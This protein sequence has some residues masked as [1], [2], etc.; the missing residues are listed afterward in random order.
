M[1]HVS[2]PPTRIG[3]PTV[4]ALGTLSLATGALEAVLTPALP[5]VQRQLGITPA[6]G[7]SLSAAMLMTGLIVTPIAGK[8]GDRYGAKRVMVWLMA[9]V[10]AGGLLSSVAPN[11]P[12]LLVGQILEGV[13]MGVMPVSFIL[14]RRYLPGHSQVAIGWIFGLFL[15]GGMLGTLMAGPLA[16]GLSW[17]AMFAVPTVVIIAATVVVAWKLPHDPPNVSVAG[18]DWPGL[19][20][21]S[22]SL[23]ALVAGLSALPGAGAPPIAIVAVILATVV[24]VTGFVLVERRASAPMIDLTM[25]ARPG[26]RIACVLTLV[27]CT[28]TSVTVYLVPQLFAVSGDGY[29]FGASPT[30]IGQFLLPSLITASA[31]GPIA[32]LAVRRFGWRPVVVAGIVVLTVSLFGLAS[33]H[34]E[35]WHLV[36]GKALIALAGSISLTALIT[37]TA[38]SVDE[39]DTGI[40]TSLVL[41]ARIIGFTVGFQVGGALLTAGADPVSGVPAESGFVLGFLVAGVVTALSLLVILGANRRKLHA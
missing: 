38:A 11:L 25:L 18:M 14:A 7:A 26:M 24:L 21:L 20:L 19:V 29:G 37:G 5:L 23:L 27:I 3:K 33:T 2:T 16:E 36:V 15:G 39:G 30:T 9:V 13:M 34:S 17:H 31:G 28:G 40:A 4:A 35:V 6:Q 8:L 12:V 10:S 1:S 41:V 22:A 32:G